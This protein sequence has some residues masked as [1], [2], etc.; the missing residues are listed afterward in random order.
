MELIKKTLNSTLNL[1]FFLLRICIVTLHFS[2]LCCSK[3]MMKFSR[4]EA[5]VVL[6]SKKINY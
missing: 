2:K 5:V 3:L 6:E 4:R 1:F